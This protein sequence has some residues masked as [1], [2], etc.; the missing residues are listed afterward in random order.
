MAPI[1]YV[2]VDAF[3][4]YY[5]AIK[6]S[7]YKWLNLDALCR[8]LLP[9]AEIRKVKY[10]TAKVQPTIGNPDAPHRQGLY[11]RALR[12]LPTV[13]VYKGHFLRHPVRAYL[14]NPPPTGPNTAEVWRTD[15]KGSDV[16][17]AVH[18]VN[19]AHHGRFEQAAV[20]SNDSDIAEAFRLVTR[21]L[22]LPVG[23]INPCLNGGSP[24]KTLNQVASFRR[25]LRPGQLARSLFPDTLSDTKGSFQKPQGW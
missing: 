11:L 10:F 21:D 20:I 23:F 15:E 18:L 13:E 8:H 14:V 6:G 2:Y 22:G 4:L 9:Q 19:D 7:P 25:D 1:T 12:T 17:L 24:S 3:N 16:N 5:R